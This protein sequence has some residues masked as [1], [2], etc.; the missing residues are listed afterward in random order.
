[1]RK[2]S[3]LLC[4]LT[5]NLL[6]AEYTLTFDIDPNGKATWQNVLKQYRG[7]SFTV[8]SREKYLEL[9]NAKARVILT[10]N[11]MD[12]HVLYGKGSEQEQYEKFLA[13]QKELSAACLEL[14]RLIKL[15]SK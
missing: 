9:V 13:Y 11:A 10:A 4:L 12:L 8:D 7:L 3:I 15:Y 14:K 6:G 5:I 1:M 2:L